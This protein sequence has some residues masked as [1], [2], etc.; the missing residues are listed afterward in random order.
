MRKYCLLLALLLLLTSCGKAADISE[1]DIPQTPP[2]QSV[3]VDIYAINDLHGKLADT[4]AQPGVDE[5]S[6]YLRQ[7]QQAGNTLLLATGDMWQG[8]AESNLTGGQIVTEWMNEMGF[9]AMT[10]GGHEYDWGEEQI[11]RNQAL[12]QFPFLGINIYDRATDQRVDYCQSSAVVEV[13]G[14]QIGIIG[15]IGN[16]YYSI[17][18]EHTKD[19]YFKTDDALTDLVKAESDKLRSEGV[20]CIVY[21][22]HDG[23]DQ[24]ATD[25]TVSDADL[26][27]YYDIALSDGYVDLVFEAD[28]HFR[29][30]LMDRHGVYHLQSGGNNSGISH[31]Q[32]EI[33]AASRKVTVATAQ[34]IPSA[35]YADGEDDPLLQ[36]LLDKYSEQISDTNRIV[37]TNRWYRTKDNLSQLAAHVYATAGVAKWG[38]D[39][40]IVLGGGY[41]TCRSPGNLPAGEVSYGQLLALFPFDNPITLCRIRGEDLVE[42]FLET[43]NENYYVK[44]TDYYEEIRND[45]DPN[46]FYYVVTDTYT[47]DYP[48]NHLTVV[49]T[50]ADHLFARDLL[51]EY[52]ADG[53]L[54]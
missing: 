15:A 12:A 41:L 47:S 10:M 20:D 45:I 44:T 1:T 30:T 50:Y 13:E 54:A 35:T 6:T 22:L 4:A 32:V 7:A 8:A 53:G 28:T 14:V 36:Q 18:P 52:I 24:S 37:G 33:D 2:S 51:A 23:Y 25:G 26:K 31:A 46:A 17:S 29:Y 48:Y 43:D 42:R 34:R 21:T 16:C 27:A 49:D 19:V 38:G 39:Y 9:A 11:R 3:T 5:L 40:D